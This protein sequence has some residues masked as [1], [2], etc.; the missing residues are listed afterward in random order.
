M[1]IETARRA[2]GE[3]ELH[4]LFQPHQHSRTARFLAEFIECLRFADRV[5]V[6]EVY[7]A[8]T[9][10]DG[11]VTAGAQD[12]A[13]GLVAA[14]VRSVAPGGLEASLPSFVDGLPEN[15]AALV[16]GAGDVGHIRDELFRQLALRGPA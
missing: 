7:G 9:H 3:G 6:T 13:D 8:R 15:C 5:V 1:T 4:V 16:L 11:E 10:I 12:I 14:G 2:L